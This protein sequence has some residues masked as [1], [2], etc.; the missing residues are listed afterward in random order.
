MSRREP[1][2]KRHRRTEMKWEDC[3]LVAEAEQMDRLL[4]RQGYERAPSVKLW[5]RASGVIT[6]RYV[7]RHRRQGLALTLTVTT[8][9]RMPLVAAEEAQAVRPAATA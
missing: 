1:S 3:P 2:R 5:V 9:L 4:R 7:W 8:D 6:C